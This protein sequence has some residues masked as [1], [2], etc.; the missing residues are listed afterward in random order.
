[1]KDIFRDSTLGQV[2]RFATRGKYLP[3]LENIPG[4]AL[5]E[6]FNVEK[7]VATPS[8]ANTP[9][10]NEENGT[11]LED[12][13]IEAQGAITSSLGNSI[14][15]S[16]LYLHRSAS[17]ATSK[18]RNIVPTLTRDGKILVTWYT[19]DDPENPQNWSTFKKCWVAFVI[20][21]VSNRKL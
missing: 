21:Y 11:K 17:Q 19:I 6:S 5:P 9:S 12:I 14:E 16:G 10:V 13:D 18:S 8:E 20:W 2:I 3:H 15:D 1:M 4:F 7:R